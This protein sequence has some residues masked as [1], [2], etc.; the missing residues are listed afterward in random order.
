MENTFERAFDFA[1][2]YTFL[3][4]LPP[5]ISPSKFHL[6]YF[7]IFSSFTFF[8]RSALPLVLESN[9]DLE[10]WYTAIFAAQVSMRSI[11]F[12]LQ[13][14][15][16]LDLNNFIRQFLIKNDKEFIKIW[17]KNKSFTY[18]KLYFWFQ[19]SA[20]VYAS[21]VVYHKLIFHFENYT[22][23][24][25]LVFSPFFN[26]HII[27]KWIYTIFDTGFLFFE[28][29]QS[30]QGDIVIIVLLDFL[31]HQLLYLKNS[32]KLDDINNK[33]HIKSWIENH[34]DALR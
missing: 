24:A 19:F 34:V 9:K 30:L 26:T 15:K 23:T 29:F 3:S 22:R 21:L 18:T 7:S 32:L 27:I 33:V 20:V 11:A 4:F 28:L 5:F 25:F 1:F 12:F 16:F 31:Y 13:R 10:V 17:N 8:C 2:R 6:C 14:E